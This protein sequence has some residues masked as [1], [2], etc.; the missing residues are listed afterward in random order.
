[1]EFIIGCNY[2]ASNA[3][4]KMWQSWDE[5]VVKKD[6]SI[7]AENGI[8]YIRVFP[9][10]SD[11]QPVKALVSWA[12][13][14]SRYAMEDESEPDNPYFLDRTMLCRF[15]RFLDVCEENGI[16]VIVGLITGWMSGG[17]FVPSALFGKKLISDSLSQYFEQ[18]FIK[19]FVSEF[20]ERE[21]IWAWDLGNECDCLEQVNDRYQAAAWV[22]MIANAIRSADSSRPILSGTAGGKVKGAWTINDQAEFCDM[23]TTHPYPFFSQHGIVDRYLSLRTTMY[24]TA[25]NKMHSDIGKKPCLMEELGTLGPSFCSDEASADFLR[26]SLFSL[27]ANGSS[28]FMWW[29]ANEQ[30]MLEHFPYTHNML[31]V[32]LGMLKADLTPKPILLEM[33]RLSALFDGELGQPLAPAKEDGVILLTDSQDQMGIGFISHILTKLAHLNCKFEYADNN[34]PDSKLYIIPSVTEAYSM[35][36]HRF[37]ELKAKIA[38]GADLYISL[39]GT[40]LSN[41]EQLC[42]VK[43]LDSYT[44][45]THASAQIGSDTVDLSTGRTLIT[46]SAGAKVL[47][48]DTDGKPCIYENAYGKGRVFVITAPIEKNL[49]GVHNAD[50]SA[51]ANVYR[52]LLGTHTDTSVIQSVAPSLVYTLHPDGD[53]YTLIILNHT[54][55]SLK[56][57]LLLADTYRIEKVLYGNADKINAFDAC[58]IKIKK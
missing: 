41:F 45:Q 50:F 30:S 16:K 38:D 49:L 14:I 3:G 28:G 17:M 39:D 23:L 33:A 46:E 19:G 55:E 53:C 2:W 9:L 52:L 40:I 36:K 29:C 20:K 42:G 48:R 56:T 25:I 31:E 47:A 8:K 4:T 6:I 34:I 57:N 32:H 15:E 51:Y 22:A 1:M 13:N 26:I 18:L 7:L 5:D 35:T 24:P 21:I 10:W 37:D 43:I 27:L 12:G 11:F 54:A 44:H 58:V